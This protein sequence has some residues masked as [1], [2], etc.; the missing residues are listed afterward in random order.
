MLGER[1]WRVFENARAEKGGLNPGRSER[2]EPRK[3]NTLVGRHRGWRMSNVIVT[4]GSNK[5]NGAGMFNAIG[6]RVDAFV[7]VRRNAERERPKKSERGKGGNRGTRRNAAFHGAPSLCPS[8][9][10]RNMFL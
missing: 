9:E 2:G 6:I 10:L 8:Q 7:Q 1:G 3:L 4:S 5:G